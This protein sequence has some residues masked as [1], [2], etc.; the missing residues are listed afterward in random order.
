MRQ[1]V[2]ST[3]ITTDASGVLTSELRY[4]AF[5]D[6]RYTSGTIPTRYRF[7]GQRSDSYINLLDYGS[8]RYDFLISSLCPNRVPPLDI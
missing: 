7:T 2:G 8:R 4:R 6:T 3:A 1:A 5:G